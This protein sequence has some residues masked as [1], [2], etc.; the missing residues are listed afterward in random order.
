MSVSVREDLAAEDIQN[1]SHPQAH[2]TVKSPREIRPDS[3]QT[4][5]GGVGEAA[6]F[7]NLYTHKTRWEIYSKK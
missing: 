4:C 6:M 1:K 3:R 2:G 7:V 5:G